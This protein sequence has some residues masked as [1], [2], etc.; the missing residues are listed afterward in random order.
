M[1][2]IRVR[3][4]VR[5]SVSDRYPCS[6]SAI[7]YLILLSASVSAP[8]Y[9]PLGVAFG[10]RDRVRVCVRFRDRGSYP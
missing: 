8:A 3:V 4:R 6:E 1:P 7:C 5:G 10:V 9:P 2:V